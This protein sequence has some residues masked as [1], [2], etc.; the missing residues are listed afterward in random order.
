MGMSWTRTSA[1]TPRSP[2]AKALLTIGLVAA[3]TGGTGLSSAAAQARAA[4]PQ[5]AAADPLAAW[6]ITGINQEVGGGELAVNPA[7]STVYLA[8]PNPGDLAVINGL[9]GQVTGSLAVPGGATAAAVN[10]ATDTIYAIGGS[11]VTVLDAK[12]GAVT[13]TIP[14]T[15]SPSQI[16]VDQETNTSYV[17]N[18]STVS[19]IDGS[20][21]TV[22]HTINVG[23]GLAGIATDPATNKVYVT[24][25][26]SIR[27]PSTVSVIDG[28]TN[29]VT[30]TI[31]VGV[32][33]AHLTVDPVT[34]LIYIANSDGTLSELAGA[35]NTVTDTIDA[36]GYAGVTADPRT[37]TIYLLGFTGQLQGLNARDNEIVTSIDTSDGDPDTQG[38]SLAADPGA[39]TI[40]V[41]DDFNDFDGQRNDLN[42]ITSCRSGAVPTA[43]SNCAKL[44]AGFDPDAVS[45]S[46]AADGVAVNSNPTMLAMATADGGKHC[47]FF[48]L[49][50]NLDFNRFGTPPAGDGLLFTSPD[51]GWIFGSWH[52]TDG[53]ASWQHNAPGLYALAMAATPA[54]VYA[55]VQPFQG[56]GELFESPIGATSWSQV[57]AIT[58]AAT[59]LAASGHSVWLTSAAHLWDTTDGRHWRRYPTRCPGTGYRLAGVTATSPSQVAFLCARPAGT[60]T[61][62]PKE[63]LI[64]TD[65]GRTVHLAGAAP[66][67]GIPQAFASPPGD[68]ELITIAAS[69]T[70][71][72]DKSWLYRSVNGGKTWTTQVIRHY[73]DQAFT[74]LTY[75]TRTSGWIDIASA[76]GGDELHTTDG[77]RTWHQVTF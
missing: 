71:S 66:A 21:N 61:T 45:F 74:S 26:A 64:S 7:T 42:V 33:A 34:D 49:P 35:T 47:S 70:N 59:G 50:P 11:T 24:S 4:A 73:Q 28:A 9:T 57:P 68:P 18:A 5:A 40:Y 46:S 14:D 48:H 55:A 23:A 76:G 41:T 31:G 10:P 52:T 8:G 65:G 39:G 29:T 63:V 77:G 25:F 22:T 69:G 58:A 27:S 20:T 32:G 13:G 60:T 12:T 67:L 15:G 37:D 16:A 51:N 53:G 38:A 1:S 30:A 2:L 56:H 62:D 54:T 75:T 72:A 17:L 36:D 3:L 43:G 6:G 19:V 44:A